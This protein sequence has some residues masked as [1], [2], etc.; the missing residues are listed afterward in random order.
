VSLANCRSPHQNNNDGQIHRT[1][2]ALNMTQTTSLPSSNN[3]SWLTAALIASQLLLLGG[4]L[5]FA[6][7]W[8]KASAIA[9]AITGLWL[10]WQLRSNDPALQQLTQLLQQANG[11]Q[12]DLSVELQLPAGSRH[13]SLAEHYNSLLTR[14]R[15]ILGSIQQHN[16]SI[17]L[18]S[19]RSR[20]LAEQSA[21][22]AGSQ[23]QVSALVF[24]SSEQTSLAVQE[25]SQR[26]NAIAAVNSRNLELARGSQQELAEVSRQVA[27]IGD[28]MSEF[29]GTIEQLQDSSKN[30]G[31]LLGT[32]QSF[33]AQT[34]M[35][36][37][38]AAIEAARAGEQGRGFAVVAD[39]VRSL[40]GKVGSAADQIQGLVQTMDQAV[41][42]ADQGTRDMLERSQQASAAIA[43]S[44]SQFAA[45][46]GDFEAAN[47]DLLMVSSALEQLSV[48]NR[49]SHD[50]STEIRN[51]SLRIGQDMQT[52]FV[53]A[54]GLRDGTNLALQQLAGFRLGQGKLEQVSDMLMQ[55]RYKL[56]AVMERLADS[57]VNLFDEHYSPIPNTNPQKHDAS[58]VAPFRQAAQPLIDEW[59]SSQGKDGIIYCLPTND[60][61]Y[62]PSARRESSHP[63]TGNPEVDAFKS[64]FMRFLIT[65]KVDLEN[66]RNCTHL[67][68][69]T[70]AIP[71]DVLCFVLF[72]PLYV[73]GRHWGTL[74][75]GLLPQVLG[76]DA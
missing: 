3:Q 19:G 32:V 36:A 57:G 35:L 21:K 71:G 68:F 8:A 43:A 4:V 6:P 52:S 10:I 76:V 67:G 73:R 16:L 70:F 25:V 56:E 17:A 48:T 13:A 51:L 66:L 46:V 31:S 75:T 59:H 53:T 18:A 41:A 26:S 20:L 5:L 29:R 44:S 50:H 15:Q 24:Q 58:W 11:P 45:M 62:L 2:K 14:L 22:S 69:G 64:N 34:N 39:E 65:N 74:G 40:A 23:D 1:L 60:L 27:G 38:N 54:D 37:L 49:E 33:A 9:V 12:L 30:I 55:R 61:G 72:V 42:G 47:G 28:V 7:G 63:P